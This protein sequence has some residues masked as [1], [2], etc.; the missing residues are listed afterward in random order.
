MPALLR[1][2]DRVLEGFL[3]ILMAGMVLDVTWQVISRFLL[4]DPSSVTEEIARFLLI[5]IGLLGGAYAFRKRAHLGID[6][7][8]Q[9]FSGWKRTAAAV[10][11]QG[12]VWVFALSVMV[13]GGLRLVTLTLQLNQVSASLGLKMGWVYLVLPLSGAL[14]MLYSTAEIITALRAGV[15]AAGAGGGDT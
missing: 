10:F 1:R 9:R 4:R 2:I 3:A 13:L 8:T 11:S 7:L 12:C 5:W 6:V 15:D 14:I